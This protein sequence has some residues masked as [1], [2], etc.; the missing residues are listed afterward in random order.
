MN[1]KET[2]HRFVKMLAN[3]VFVVESLFLMHDTVTFSY[4]LIF[5]LCFARFPNCF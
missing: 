4:G 2:R 1:L 3:A 5:I